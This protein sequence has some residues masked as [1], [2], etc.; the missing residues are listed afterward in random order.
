MSEDEDLEMEEESEEETMGFQGD[1]DQDTDEE[2]K[3]AFAAGLL[4]PGMNL[5][6]EAP[7]KKEF[8]NNIP[9]IN[10]KTEEIH[11]DLPW[12]ERLDMINAP[13]PIAPELAYKEEQHSQERQKALRIAKDGTS[14]EEDLVHN[15]F[16]REMLFYRQAQSAVLEGL[17]RLQSMN[18]ATKRP[19]DYFAQMAKTDEHMQKIRQKLLSKQE[20]QEKIEKVKKLRELKKYGKKVQVEVQQNRL[21]E[22]KQ[23]MEN[24]KKFRKG[25]TDNLDFLEDGAGPKG[26]NN[27]KRSVNGKR[28]AK[29]EK[30]G[31][32]GK[33][34][35]MKKNTKESANDVSEYRPSRAPGSKG[36]NKRPGKDRRKKMQNHNKKKKRG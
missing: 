21:K 36:G 27:E 16:K 7:T 15:D 24:V 31:F 8:K 6:G 22:K 32:G 20:V 9:L 11:K 1:S 17:K 33:K 14:I 30:W 13:A 25:K 29:N 28:K 5:I 3:E 34:R 19:E 4:K 2:L 10:Q 26:G 12:V 18:I 23:L 35:G